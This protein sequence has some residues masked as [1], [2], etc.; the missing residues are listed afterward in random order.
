MQ[1][2]WLRAHYLLDLFDSAR[3]GENPHSRTL[4]AEIAGWPKPSFSGPGATQSIA[5]LLELEFDH[6]LELGRNHAL[7]G[8]AKVLARFD[9]APPQHRSEV[10][11]R[12]L[13]LKQIASKDSPLATNA[14]LRLFAYCKT[15]IQ[16]AAT[17]A[18]KG[19]RVALSH[20]LYPLY[21]ANPEP[22][23]HKAAQ[24]RPPPPQLSNLWEPMRFLL[25]QASSTRISPTLQAQK[26]WLDIA[27][28]TQNFS[29][30]ITDLANLPFVENVIP[31]DDYPLLT[32][33]APLASALQEDQ[34]GMA[35][36]A[37]SAQSPATETLAAAKRAKAAGAI[38]LAIVVGM[39]Q[40]LSVPKGDYWSEKTQRDGNEVLR[41]GQIVFSL[42]PLGAQ[43]APNSQI[44]AKANLW[45]PVRAGLKLHLL[46]SPKQ[47]RLVGPSGNL[48]T[49]AT[50]TKTADPREQLRT[51]L[52]TVR[53]GYPDEDGLILVPST[54][55]THASL[56]W[57]AQAAA[58]DAQG[59]RLFSMLALADHGPNKVK[60]GSAFLKLIRLRSRAK[61][62]VT[63]NEVAKALPAAR[64]CFL[65]LLQKKRNTKPGT[66]RMERNA[67]GELVTTP[68]RSPLAKCTQSAFAAITEEKSIPAISVQYSI[69]S[70]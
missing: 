67:S 51:I 43:T 65:N 62:T 49:I 55:A 64:Q 56:L 39:K 44:R 36:L 42:A 11:Q 19:R 50:Q 26:R 29:V 7:G 66:I 1:A 68:S 25:N 24:R 41:A 3:F 61:V 53:Q 35:A 18:G 70:P 31:Y 21:Q 20:C 2:A 5:E 48:A 15:A 8:Q 58:V 60:A 38:A 10:F 14:R 17:F 69:T 23:F 57:A 6:V 22:Y 30:G 52:N 40:T 37:I 16:D 54:E 13:E 63:P 32:P 34:R 4:L 33:S 45:D 12:L 59:N 47:W 46:I 9:A 27:K 28:E